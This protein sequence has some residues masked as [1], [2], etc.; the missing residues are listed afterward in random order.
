[1][2]TPF[3]MNSSNLSSPSHDHDVPMPFRKV[4]KKIDNP[5]DPPTNHRFH[6]FLTQYNKWQHYRD[7]GGRFMQSSLNV[8][9]FRNLNIVQLFLR[10][11]I[12]NVRIIL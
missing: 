1:M 5:L 7:R 2:G 11:A 10:K 9:L 3:Y 4:L 8:V 6:T 12:L